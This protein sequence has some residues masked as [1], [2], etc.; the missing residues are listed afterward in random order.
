MPEL[1]YDPGLPL[2]A[3]T[4]TLAERDGVVIADCGFDNAEGDR[5]TGYLVFP[6]GALLAAGDDLAGVVYQHSTGGREGFLSEAIQ[7]AEAGG[8]ALSLPIADTGDAVRNLRESIFAIRRGADLLT[9]YGADRLGCVGHSFGAMTAG[10]VSGIDDRFRCFVFD[11]GLSGLSVHYRE[12]PYPEIRKLRESMTPAEYEPL[13]ALLE[14][15]DCGHFV[16][17]AAPA[18]LLFQSAW[19]DPNV[20][21]ENAEKFFAAASSPKEFRWY[22]T[23]HVI[24]DVAAY[25]DRA[26][27]LAEH[28]ALPTLPGR[29]RA[30]T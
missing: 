12:T 9:A 17:M 6:S 15:Y 10:T 2:N 14:P 21:R 22:D 26:R 20:S 3:R 18:A 24:N 1:D 27:F 28:L 7:V 5:A 11:S 4:E 19:F 13:L 29:L 8:I 25:T 16:G 30:R 23:G